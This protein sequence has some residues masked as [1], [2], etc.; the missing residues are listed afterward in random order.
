M[1]LVGALSLDPL[2]EEKRHHLGEREGHSFQANDTG[3][4]NVNTI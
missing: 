4:F 2:S 1:E 3:G